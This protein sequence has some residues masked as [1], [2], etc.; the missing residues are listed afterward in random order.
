MFDFNCFGRCSCWLNEATSPN[1]FLDSTHTPQTRSFYHE[2]TSPVFSPV[3]LDY[4]SAFSSPPSEDVY[5]SPPNTPGMTGVDS[6]LFSSYSGLASCIPPNM[7]GAWYGCCSTYC[8]SGVGAAETY[9]SGF[10]SASCMPPNMD[11]ASYGSFFTYCVSGWSVA[12]SGLFS[13]SCIPPN[14]DGAW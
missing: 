6:S 8:G 7:L 2:G 11:G 10:F 9:M 1:C 5:Y 4:G 13:A 12:S 14:K 3:K